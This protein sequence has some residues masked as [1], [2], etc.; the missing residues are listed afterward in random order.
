VT[1]YVVEFAFNVHAET[2][3][4]AVKLAFDHA[5]GAGEANE[6]FV[7]ALRKCEEK[8]PTGGI[9]GGRDWMC[10]ITVKEHD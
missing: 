1:R 9:V 4:D 3:A 5:A 7:T 10:V 8:L 2:P 6:V